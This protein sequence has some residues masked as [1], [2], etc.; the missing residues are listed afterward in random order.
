[1]DIWLIFA[2]LCLAAAGLVCI[3]VLLVFWHEA[4]V[5]DR[6]MKEINSKDLP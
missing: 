3:T 1:M 4:K 6:C 2:A 5:Y